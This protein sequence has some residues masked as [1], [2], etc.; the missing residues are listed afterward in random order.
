[1]EPVLEAVGRLY[2][3]YAGPDGLHLP[4]VTECYRAAKRGAP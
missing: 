1:V 2:D 4:Y 3:E